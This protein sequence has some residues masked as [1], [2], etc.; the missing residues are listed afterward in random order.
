MKKILVTG[1]AGFIGFHLVKKL[2]DEGFIVH[3]IDNM[4]NYYDLK[5]KKLRQ[6]DLNLF[7]KKYGYEKKYKFHKIDL[8]DRL[9]L[10]SLFHTECF[11]IVI[12]LAA[13]AGV[14]YSIE[15]PFAYSESN[16]T[17]FVNILECCRESDIKHLIFA[18]SS[19]VY[20][21][22]TKHPFGTNDC[23]D[24]PVSL[25][26]ATKKCNELMAHSYSHLFNLPVTGLR[27]FT[28]YGTHGRPDMAYFKFT[29]SIIKGLPIDVYNRGQ[30]KRDF[31]Y[32]DDVVNGIILICSKAPKAMNNKLTK[33]KA[34]YKI[35]NIGNNN[36]VTLKR[37]IS[38]IEDAV[39]KK[40]NKINLPMQAGDVPITYADVSDLQRDFNY[41][42]TTSIESGIKNFVDWYKSENISI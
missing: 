35:Y 29:E 7:S 24:Y 22:N 16:L 21:M 17:G 14:R 20:G 36:P 25:Y 11:D 2:L 13:Q 1:S 37:F 42:P 41:S 15:E 30:M 28:V 26:A 9:K 38:A 5:H 40:A 12:N 8:T 23:T 18:S 19:S 32:V 39:G 34:P 6:N 10:N 27:F 4:N 33:S 31:T 3:G